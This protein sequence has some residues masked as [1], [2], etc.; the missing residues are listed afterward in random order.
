MLVTVVLAVLTFV[1]GV[2]I[3]ALTGVDPLSAMTGAAACMLNIGPG[4]G[5]FGPAANYSEV[6]PVGKWTLAFLMVAGRLEWF[7]LMVV[8]TIPFWRK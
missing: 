4:L 1:V 8:F 2:L 7:N 5:A 6:T 3:L